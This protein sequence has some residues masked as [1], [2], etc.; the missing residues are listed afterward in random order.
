M[1]Q[2]STVDGKMTANVIQYIHPIRAGCLPVEGH[3]INVGRQ[4]N[5]CELLIECFEGDGTATIL[6]RTVSWVFWSKS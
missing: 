6:N 3:L 4:E 1:S 2:R 5:H